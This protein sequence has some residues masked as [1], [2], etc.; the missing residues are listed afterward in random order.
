MAAKTKLPTLP[1][2]P[3]YMVRVAKT[4]YDVPRWYLNGTAFERYESAFREVFLMEKE[5]VRR[6]WDPYYEISIHEKVGRPL[7]TPISV[8]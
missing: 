3:Y 1:P 8:G 2:R 7:V 6:G 5:Y 4:E